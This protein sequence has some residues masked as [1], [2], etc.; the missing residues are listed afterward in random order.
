[1]LFSVDKTKTGKPCI[2]FN[3]TKYRQQRILKNGDVSWRCLGKSCGAS[4]KTD[5]GITQVITCNQKHSGVHPVTMRTLLSP[6]LKSQTATAASPAVRP[7]PCT[8]PAL[9][10]CAIP[11][12]STPATDL[13]LSDDLPGLRQELDAANKVLED[14]LAEISRLRKEIERL[15]SEYQ[16]L[17]NHTI[18]SDTRLPEFTDQIFQVSTSRVDQ[19]A[20]A[21][22][23]VNC[24]VQCEPYLALPE[25]HLPTAVDFALPVHR[26]TETG[27]APT[28]DS[29]QPSCQLTDSA[30]QCE[31]LGP[32]VEDEILEAE[33]QCLK[34]Q[35]I[36]CEDESMSEQ[37][38]TRVVHKKSDKETNYKKG[39]NTHSA[40]KTKNKPN[41]P[42]HRRRKNKNMRNQIT[43]APKTLP[44]SSSRRTGGKT[45]GS[46]NNCEWHL[47]AR[48]QA[49]QHPE[50]L[51]NTQ[52]TFRA[53][54]H[55][56][57]LRE[58]ARPTNTEMVIVTLPHRHDLELDNPIQ[59]ESALVNV[60]IQEL[61]VRY[62]TRV[63]DF[64]RISRQCFTA[65]G[66]HLNMS[67]KR[68]L[69]ELVVESLAAECTV[70]LR[71]TEAPRP[72]LRNEGTSSE[73]AE[74]FV[75]PHDSYADALN[76]VL[77]G[78]FNVDA[79]NN[80]HPTT[81]RL[82]DMLRSFGLELLVKSPTR[83]TPTTQTAINNVV[84]S[85]PKVAVS[86]V[87]TAISDHYGQ[88][89]IIMGK[90]IEREPKIT[91]IIR[92]TRP[93]NIALP[94]ASLSKE[95]WNFINFTEP[96][97]Q[98]FQSFNNCLNYHLDLCCPTKTIK[99]CR[100]KTVTGSRKEY[101]FRE[102]N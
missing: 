86:V 67:G 60:F 54:E 83:V 69:A 96:V 30:V 65:L 2:L 53:K 20:R 41:K 40:T 74:P 75:L 36:T 31:L 58:T 94:N 26:A 8:P 23:T 3:G 12:C 68:K 35:S 71:K 24:G 27:R 16:K 43:Q 13:S 92:D 59:L 21:S 29:A 102:K 52:L 84:S 44:R 37:P 5:A 80:T 19:T 98:Q 77:M 50:A 14:P 79:L 32:T 62:G 89:A 51:P 9:D 7:V 56:S 73:T 66:Q 99:V 95:Q 88:E 10:S 28:V 42:K 39:Q 81:I 18:E 22:A 70:P 64:N 17:R 100:K 4:I 45:G 63:V 38:W 72:T 47:Q 48:G 55:I 91:K 57:S 49:A 93:N 61:A 87:N 78:D 46:C 85:I 34:L 76:Y 101:W 82:V 1:M 33:V 90:Q 25:D 11:V 97:E 6:L 15:E